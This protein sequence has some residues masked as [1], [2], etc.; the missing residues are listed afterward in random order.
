MYKGTIQRFKEIV[1]V[2]AFYGFGYIVDNKIKKDNKSPENLRKACEELG[3]TFVKIGQI[4][5]TRPDILPP[6]YINELSK[7]QDNVA[8]QDFESI[9][10]VFENSCGKKIEDVFLRFDKNP[11]ASAS[12]AQVHN[13]VLKDGR[14][15]VV[16]IQRPLIREKM[17][18]DLSIL[19]KLASLTKTKFEDALIDPLEAINELMESTK[20]ELDFTNE[21]L[22]LQKFREFNKNVAFVYAPYVVKELSNS[23]VLVM[24]RIDGFKINNMA[25]LKKG[26]YDLD[27]LGRKFT[28]SYCKQVFTDGFFHGDPHPGNLLISG[29]KICYIDFGI[30]GCF[31]DSLKSALNDVI[32]AVAYRDPGKLVA[33]LMSIGIKKGYVNRNKLYEDIDYLFASYLSTSLQNIKISSMLQEVYEC[34][35]SNNIKLPKDLTILIRALILVEGVAAEI[36]PDINILDIVVPFVKEGSISKLIKETTF[37]QVLLRTYNFVRSSSYLPSKIIELSD[38]LIS[39]RAKVQLEFSNVDK[40]INDIN[41][42]ANRIIFGII[43]ASLIL[44][45]CLILNSNIGPKVSGVSVIGISGFIISGIFG[46]YLII[47]IIRSGNI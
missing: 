1:K 45:S 36:S 8:A 21:A 31:N 10:T 27:D 20:L 39:G 28:L 37:D 47:S 13:A 24:E 40:S 9:K 7:L 29:G 5:S 34:A 44:G 16:K 43:V 38:S 14:K 35:S 25:R 4:L 19:Y 32:Y 42:I 15:V 30:V 23:S 11:L 12:I 22:N 3:P 33:V 2:L 18:L 17:K 26:G 46:L 41:K 6:E